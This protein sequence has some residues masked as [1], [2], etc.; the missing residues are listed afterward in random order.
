MS[1]MPIFLKELEK[2]NELTRRSSDEARDLDWVAQTSIMP[3]NVGLY[4]L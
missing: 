4:V 1:K 3:I 2:Q